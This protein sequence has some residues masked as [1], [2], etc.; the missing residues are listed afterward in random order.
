MKQK[1]L[2]RR[3]ALFNTFI[4]LFTTWLNRGQLDFH[5]GFCV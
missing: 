1:K 5:I 2:V 4:H 3:V